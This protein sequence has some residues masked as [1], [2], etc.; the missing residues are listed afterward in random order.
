MK[1]QIKVIIVPGLCPV[2]T[3]VVLVLF[4]E[5]LVDLFLDVETVFV[6]QLVQMTVTWRVN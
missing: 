5:V 2:V 4:V 6:D 1:V 3:I